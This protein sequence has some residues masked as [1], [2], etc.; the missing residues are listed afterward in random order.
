RVGYVVDDIDGDAKR[1]ELGWVQ[2]Q[3]GAVRH[4]MGALGHADKLSAEVGRPLWAVQRCCNGSGGLAA[5]ARKQAELAQAGSLV[6]ICRGVSTRQS[7]QL[8]KRCFRCRGNRAIV[9]M[10]AG[11]AGHR[12]AVGERYEFR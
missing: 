12:R 9:S 1:T 4:V 2:S 8:A 5:R 6:V 7:A 3:L 11:T 10:N